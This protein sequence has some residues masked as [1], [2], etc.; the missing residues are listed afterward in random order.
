MR[1]RE[2]SVE[3]FRFKDENECEYEICGC[4]KKK[5]ARKASIYIFPPKS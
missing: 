5:T 3:S 4:A 2:Q 1:I